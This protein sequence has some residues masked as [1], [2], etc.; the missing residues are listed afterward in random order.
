MRIDQTRHHGP[1]SAIDYL[2]AVRWYVLAGDDVLDAIALD[3]QTKSLAQRVRRTVEELEILEN[4]RRR[5]RCLRTVCPEQTK[6]CG[7]GAH[8]GDKTA[9]GQFLVDAA[10]CEAKPWVATGTAQ[11]FS[12]TG[13]WA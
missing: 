12:V 8:T 3:K 11:M 4:D 5:R 7:G 6:R 10:C 13:G 1:P 2:R 9:P